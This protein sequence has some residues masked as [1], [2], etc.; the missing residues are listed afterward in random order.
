MDS[1]WQK[2]T[3]KNMQEVKSKSEGRQKK[4]KKKKSAGITN[5]SPSICPVPV[6]ELYDT[7][8]YP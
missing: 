6:V 1:S 8:S 5:C 2:Q 4:K 7:V 3:K